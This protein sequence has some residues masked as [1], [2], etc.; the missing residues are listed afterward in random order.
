MKTL[1]LLRYRKG[2]GE[3]SEETAKTVVL[4]RDARE[5]RCQAR[6]RHSRD[7]LTGQSAAEMLNV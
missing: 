3:R 7:F 5:R 4:L 1:G 6:L 2:W